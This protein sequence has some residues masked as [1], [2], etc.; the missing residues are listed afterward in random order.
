MVKYM[1]IAP[2]SPDV[3]RKWFPRDSYKICFMDR[4]GPVTWTVEIVDPTTEMP[5]I[6]WA[7][8]RRYFHPGWKIVLAFWVDDRLGLTEPK[9]PTGYVMPG[10]V[11]GR[12]LDSRPVCQICF[13][14]ADTPTEQWCFRHLMEYMTEIG[15]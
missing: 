9:L 12:T 15:L 4:P 2:D 13:Q 7:S 11:H 6:R 5:A 8:L 10:W 14:L 3:D 1:M